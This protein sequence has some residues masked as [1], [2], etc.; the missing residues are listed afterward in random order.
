MPRCA[1]KW[2][3]DRSAKSLALPREKR[4]RVCILYELGNGQWDIPE[5]RKALTELLPQK[6]VLEDFLVEHNFPRIGQ[7]TM[8]LNA[9]RMWR[10]KGEPELILLAIEDITERH[11]DTQELTRFNRAA[12]GAKCV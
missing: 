7:R 11:R 8:L 2:Q 5:L 4:R 10:E 1:C 12:G 9:R 6:H 3:I